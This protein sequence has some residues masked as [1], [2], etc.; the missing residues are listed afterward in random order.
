[1]HNIIC[2]YAVCTRCALWP[3]GASLLACDDHYQSTLTGKSWRTGQRKTPSRS[4]VQILSTSS[5]KSSERESMIASIGRRSALDW[6][7]SPVYK[8]VSLKLWTVPEKVSGVKLK[9][10]EERLF[11]LWWPWGPTWVGVCVWGGGN[12]CGTDSLIW[13]LERPACACKLTT[14]RIDTT[15]W[16][17]WVEIRIR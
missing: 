2:G 14:P 7:V 16:R 13:E 17:E 5:R 1:M 15:I 8:L 4:R 9:P 3:L 10:M 11:A 12:W 6:Q